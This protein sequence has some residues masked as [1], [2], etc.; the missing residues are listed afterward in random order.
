ML[1]VYSAN[2][3][4]LKKTHLSDKPDLIRALLMSVLM[5]RVVDKREARLTRAAFEQR[6]R[7][8]RHWH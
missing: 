1:L 7:E 6:G 3:H 4:P 2:S 8:R 5:S